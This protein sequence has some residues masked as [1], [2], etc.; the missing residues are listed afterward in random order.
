MG[1]DEHVCPVCKQPVAT[2]VRRHKT[3]G[4]F[5]P[6]WGPGPCRNPKCEAYADPSGARAG[7]GHQTHQVRQVH[8]RDHPE[9][10]VADES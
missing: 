10:S 6:V 9:E 4:A 3:L 8:P 5:V 7:R 2:V 1:T